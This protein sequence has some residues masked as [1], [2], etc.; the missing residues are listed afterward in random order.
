MAS[1][2]GTGRRKGLWGVDGILIDQLTFILPQANIATQDLTK[3]F[4]L[5]RTFDV[6][7]CLEVAE[8]LPEI[9]A[10]ILVESI[11]RHGSLIFFSS[12]CPWQSGERHL[13]CQWPSY[14]QSLFNRYGFACY[15]DIRPLIWED[16]DVEP[17]YRQNMFRATRQLD[18]A[19]SE[20]RILPLI[21]PELCLSIVQSRLVAAVRELLAEGKLPAASYFIDASR[22]LMAKVRH[23]F[24]NSR[25]KPE[26]RRAL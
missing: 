23:K 26:V 7:I 2:R 12:A 11:C 17:W 4:D 5:G 21:H 3:R 25:S 10:D 18:V 1:S 16:K 24:L 6:V 14:W 9:A 15:D 19:G 13:N 8:H 22:G 20:P